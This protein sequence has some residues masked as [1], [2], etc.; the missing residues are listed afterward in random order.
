MNIPLHKTLFTI[1]CIACCLLAAAQQPKP[2]PQPVMTAPPPAAPVFNYTKI[3]ANLQYA[4]IINKPTTQKPQEGDQ[5]AVH[6]QS[7]CNNRL[8]YSTVQAFKGKPALYGVTKPAY[9]G[10]LI[11]AILLMTPG[12][13]L[14][15]QVDADALFKNAKSKMPVFI[16]PGDKVQYF[17]KL[18]SIKPKAQVQKE[19]QEAFNKQMKEQ[20]EKQKVEAAKQLIKDDKT[21]KTW[22]AKKNL[23]PAKTASGLYYTTT[24]EGSGEKPVPGDSV[25]MNYTGTLLDGTKFDSNED[26][27]FKH[28]QPLNFVLGRGAV[29]KGWDEG[30]ALLKTGTKATLYI[31][32]PLAYGA[33]SRPGSGANPKGIPANSILLFDVQL[34]SSKHPASPPAVIKTD[35]L[36][37]P[38]PA[39]K[40]DSLNIPAPRQIPK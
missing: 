32:S 22:F 23:S 30:I 7:V 37:L 36:R 19:Q 24:T 6:M 28:V 12:D 11:E 2:V 40:K 4:F 9:K 26:T 27:V 35:S 25:E 14:V 34:V 38:V 3:N 17:I 18:V 5:I 15:C 10:D 16:K 1:A 13:S 8:M 21:L 39:V 33:Q 31:P 20:V 29:I